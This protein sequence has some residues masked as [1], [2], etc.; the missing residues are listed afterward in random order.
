[1]TAIKIIEVMYVIDR[2]TMDTSHGKSPWKKLNI[3]SPVC[4]IPL[5]QIPKIKIYR[6]VA[7][8]HPE[9]IDG[10]AEVNYHEYY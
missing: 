1:M 8:E 3:L 6:M 9:V 7:S 5:D 4:F 10:D 2:F